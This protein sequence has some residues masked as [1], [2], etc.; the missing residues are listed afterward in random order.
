MSE[1]RQDIVNGNWVL[2]AESRAKRPTDFREMPATP[3]NLPEVLKTCVFCPGSEHL[4]PPEIVSYP[5]G[6]DWL[7]RVVPNKYEAVGH[8]IGKHMREFYVSRPG[9]GDHEVVVTRFHNR[10]IALQD[11]A[12]IDLTLQAFVDR[13]N[14]LKLHEEVQYVHVIQNHG[15]QAGGSIAHPHSQIFAIPF[16]PERVEEELIGTRKY[17][18]AN[19]ACIYCEMILHEV[20]VQERV[21]IDDPDFLVIAPYASRMPFE[22]HILPKTHRPSFHEITIS[23]RKALARVMKQVFFRLYERMHNPAYNFYIHTVPFGGVIESK[24]HDDSLS[25]HWHIV[26][27]PRVNVWAGFELGTEVYVNAMSPEKA[28]KFFH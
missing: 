5:V 14:E 7:V 18:L 23:E 21:V 15:V 11:E 1:F 4:T 12:L 24:V 13:F 6:K 20:S 10:P 16:L 26:V 9:I 8:V 28:A 22:M 3:E 25:Y 17:F 2:I 27:L 19:G